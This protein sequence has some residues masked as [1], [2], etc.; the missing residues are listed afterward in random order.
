M[1]I[2]SRTTGKIGM[3]KSNDKIIGGHAVV[4]CGYDDNNRELIARNSWGT[5]WG[6][7]GYF[8][9]PYEYLRYCGELW[10]IIKSHFSR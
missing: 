7:K 4:I 3:P 1:S 6:D 2:N 8:Y 10:I 9:I 5:Y